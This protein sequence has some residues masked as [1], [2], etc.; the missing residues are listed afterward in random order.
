MFST[1]AGGILA[2]RSIWTLK[3]IAF[4]ACK[5]LSIFVGVETDTMLKKILLLFV[6]LTCLF[7]SSCKTNATHSGAQPSAEINIYSGPGPGGAAGDGGGA[8][9]GGAGIGG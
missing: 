4:N 6:V 9:G 3:R 7:V 2:T 1:L 8:A 5:A